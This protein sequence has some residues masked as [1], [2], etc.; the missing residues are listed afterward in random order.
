MRLEVTRKS[1]LGLRALQTLESLDRA[2]K[3]AELAELVGSSAGFLS[4]VLTPLVKAGWVRSDPGPSGGYTLIA[5]CSDVSVLNV[6]EAV[7]G[8]TD[9]G[10][11]VLE[12]RSCTESA[13]CALH[14]AWSRARVQ[15]MAELDRCTVAEVAAHP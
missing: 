3:G 7:E 12:D 5:S 9:A 10:Q 15:M 4:Q 1:E 6:I 13:N 2:A 14:G 8:P 11:C